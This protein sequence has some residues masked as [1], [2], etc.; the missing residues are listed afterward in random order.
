MYWVYGKTMEVAL[1]IEIIKSRNLF[2]YFLN[3]VHELF[4][5]DQ[6]RM[7]LDRKMLMGKVIRI[8]YSCT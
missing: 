8:I 4:N 2:K 7:I 3:I 6:L 1:K 5:F